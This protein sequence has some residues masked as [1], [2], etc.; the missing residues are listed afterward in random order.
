MGNTTI[1]NVSSA[2][3]A[4][5]VV[6]GVAVAGGVSAVAAAVAAMVAAIAAAVIAV[7]W[8]VAAVACTGLVCWA[9]VA[10]ARINAEVVMAREAQAA[11]AARTQMVI[12][13]DA[14]R[15]CHPPSG[16]PSARPARILVA[17]PRRSTP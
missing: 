14:R 8:A 2:G 13:V 6:L 16:T 7:V 5:A 12:D 9:L 17:P 1:V 10:R 3:G 4:G 15:G 11:L